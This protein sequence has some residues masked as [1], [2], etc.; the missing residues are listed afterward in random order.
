MN[1]SRILVAASRGRTVIHRGWSL[2][3]RGLASLQGPALLAA[4][5]YVAWV[6][7]AS[8]LQSLRDWSGTLWLYANCFQV[9]L[10][11]SAWAA[12]LGTAGELLLPPLLAFGLLGRFAALGLFVVNAVALASYLHSQQIALSMI[13]MQLNPA[14]MFHFIWGLLLLALSLWGPGR[15]SLDAWRGRG[16]GGRLQAA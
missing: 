10:L 5:L 9:P 1:P 8:G 4:R 2:L 6:F 11:P 13:G 15:W 7:L 16:G 14:M 12:V 3:E